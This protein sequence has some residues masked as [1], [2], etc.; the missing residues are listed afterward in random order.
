MLATIL[1]Y[2]VVVA[3][4]VAAVV[5]AFGVTFAYPVIVPWVTRTQPSAVPMTHRL[6]AHLNQ[7]LTTPVMVLVLLSGIYL[8]AD[9]DLFKQPWVTVPMVIIIVIFGLVGAFFIPQDK[10]LADLAERDLAAGGDFSAE[11]QAASRRVAIVG[12]ITGL[13]ILTAIFFMV[14]K[15]ITA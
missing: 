1:F 14:V 15:P 9:R 3:V 10:K 8:A 12:A 6:Q 11:Y 5:I 2:D 13:M 4:H 7:R